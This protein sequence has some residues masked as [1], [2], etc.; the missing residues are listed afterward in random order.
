M[1][2]SGCKCCSRRGC[3]DGGFL[4]GAGPGVANALS[5]ID[6]PMPSHSVVMARISDWTARGP[7][8]QERPTQGWDGGAWGRIL[9]CHLIC[10]V[11][12]DGQRVW[13]RIG[14]YA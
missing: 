1:P 13:R 11:V 6:A 3:L 4:N 14:F 12:E 5:Q 2:S 9:F 10:G 7:M 8:A